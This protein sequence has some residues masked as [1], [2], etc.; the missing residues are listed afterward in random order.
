MFPFGGVRWKPDVCGLGC[1][2][3]IVRLIWVSLYSLGRALFSPA[4]EV[5]RPAILRGSSDVSVPCP[6]SRCENADHQQY[7]VGGH[8]SRLLRPVLRGLLESGLG[9]SIRASVVNCWTC[10]W[11]ML[12]PRYRSSFPLPSQ[13]PCIVYC[14]FTCRYP[15]TL[16]HISPC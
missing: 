6:D 11:L 4:D 3:N 7:N 14:N 8:H 15:G 5:G 12:A 2:A 9:S 13:L 16:R 1:C 10:A